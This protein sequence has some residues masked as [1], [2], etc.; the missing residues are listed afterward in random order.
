MKP[1]R[2]PLNHFDWIYAKMKPKDQVEAF[3]FIGRFDFPVWGWLISENHNILNNNM[4]NHHRRMLEHQ[5]TVR[6][7]TWFMF[8]FL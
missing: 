8:F 4:L 6:E 2:Q 1:I 5:G 3:L 7:P